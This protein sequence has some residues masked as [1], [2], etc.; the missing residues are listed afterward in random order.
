MQRVE[1]WCVALLVCLILRPQWSAA[2]SYPERP[3]KI[4]AGT[5]AGGQSDRLAR[6]VAQGLGRIW[7]EAVVV[8]ARAGA[9]GT[10]AAEYVAHSP[11]DGYTLLLAGQSN[12]ALVA[13]QGRDIRYDPIADF[14]PICQVSVFDFGIAVGPQL[15]AKTLQDLVAWAKANPSQASFAIPGAGALPHF[16]GVMFARTAGIE[17]RAVPYRGSAAGLADLIA[18]HIPIEI[19]T[20]SDLVQMHKAGRIRVL[21]TSDKARS[22]FLPDVP[23]FAE[24]GYN[25]VATGWYGMFAPAKTPPDIVARLNAVIVDAVH[26]ADTRDRLL[27]FGLQPTGTTAAEFAAIQKAASEQWA[28]AVKASGFTPEE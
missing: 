10:I 27:A 2:Q 18:G 1:L 22:P 15:E 5:A 20:T 14:A 7:G 9:D 13:A 4:V 28:P 24:A 25:L 12:L 26:A 23:T 6:L 16:L 19:T 11:P 21:A 17:L 8:E 3:V